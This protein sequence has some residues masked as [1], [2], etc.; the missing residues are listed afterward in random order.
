MALNK[1]LVNLEEEK[2][3]EHYLLDD[4]DRRYC[5]YFGE[6][7]ARSGFGYSKTNQLIAN[8]KKSPSVKNKPEWKYKE[9]AI[10][11]IAKLLNRSFKKNSDITFIPI[12]SSKSKF[13]KDY[14]D[15]LLKTLTTA[16]SDWNNP[17]IRELIVQKED[18]EPFHNRE[19]RRDI[20]VLL[21][22]WELDKKIITPIPR[23]IVIFDD[24]LTTGCHFKAAKFLL[25]QQYSEIPIYGIFIAR[26]AIE[27]EIINLF[28][29]IEN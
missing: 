18:I 5:F 22:V 25:Q 3:H 28:E 21:D 13:H 27:S 23:K 20:R 12:P 29:I 11:E 17:D 9:S 16:F 6:Y 24:L 19:A 7:T 10:Q 8:F 14:D 4:K 15:R 2:L 1:R 26:R